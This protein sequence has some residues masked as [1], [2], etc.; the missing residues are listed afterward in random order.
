MPNSR[1]V[2]EMVDLY[3]SAREVL[4]LYGHPTVQSRKTVLALAEKMLDTDEQ[5]NEKA[6][7]MRFVNEFRNKPSEKK[8]VLNRPYLLDRSMQLAAQRAQVQP[9]QIGIN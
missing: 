5:L 9:P 8:L 1:K 3:Q 4:K 6:A 7:L 2:Q